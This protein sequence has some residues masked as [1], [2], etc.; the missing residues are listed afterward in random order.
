MPIIANPVQL[1]QEMGQSVW[2]DGLQRELMRSGQLHR[3][4][5]DGLVSGVMYNSRVH[6]H[7]VSTRQE[8]ADDIRSLIAGGAS[9][10]QVRVTLLLEDAR[11]A[12]EF[13][14]P[15]YRRASG[16]EGLVSV[17]CMTSSIDAELMTAD[18]R[19]TWT[20]IGRPNV[21][22]EVPST[23]AGTVALRR[24]VAAGINVNMAPIFSL[25][26]YRAILDALASG[27]EERKRSGVPLAGIAVVTSFAINRIDALMNSRLSQVRGPDMALAQR[28]LNGTAAALARFAYQDCRKLL[29]SARWQALSAYG[30]AAPRLLWNDM[31]TTSPDDVRY[32]DA[33]I[34]PNTITSLSPRT[35]TAYLDHGKPAQRLEDL[36]AVAELFADMGQL[37][38]DLES[39]NAELEAQYIA[40]ASAGAR[41]CVTAIAH[42]AGQTQSKSQ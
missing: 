10:E 23:A 27:L 6:C 34:G 37:G 19:V 40:D 22:L 14:E 17:P 25:E 8:Y 26:R 16:M 28:W 18:A 33:L 35:L 12:A 4:M 29:R 36:T 5:R 11:A 15:M 9:P 39:V 3:W 31:E 20:S 41:A 30:A 1:L 21:L 13:M 42:L 24:L 7:A 38:I 32:V 2:L